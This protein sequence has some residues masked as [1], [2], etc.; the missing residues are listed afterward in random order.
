MVSIIILEPMKTMQMQRLLTS[1]VLTLLSCVCACVPPHHTSNSTD[2]GK[3]I[4]QLITDLVWQA[5]L[6]GLQTEIQVGLEI[7]N[8]GSTAIRFPIMDKITVSLLSSEGNALM[9]EGG[10]DVL[11]PGKPISD[12][13]QPGNKFLID[14]QGRL[15]WDADN[16][17]ELILKDGLGSV[18]VI[19]PLKPGEYMLSMTYENQSTTDKSASDV[20]SGKAQISPVSILITN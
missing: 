16:Q 18:W 4:F 11:I 17:L 12:P 19:G 15:G 10:Q 5:P 7:T 20:W 2:Q 14:L 3:V 8:H 6:Q 9:M 13:V 1:W